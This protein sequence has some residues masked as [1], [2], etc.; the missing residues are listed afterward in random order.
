MGV[1]PKGILYH[2]EDLLI[3]VIVLEHSK[4]IL[5]GG[6]FLILD[7]SFHLSLKLFVRRHDDDDDDGDVQQRLK[8]WTLKQSI[9][10]H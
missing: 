8:Y 3:L 5:E 4:Y 6:I 2:R 9:D 7:N 10:W 1:E